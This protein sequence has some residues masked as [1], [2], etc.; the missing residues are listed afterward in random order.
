MRTAPE[1]NPSDTEFRLLDISYLTITLEE[2]PYSDRFTQIYFVFEVDSYTRQVTI[3]YHDNIH[4]NITDSY[5]SI[6][7][8][9]VAPLV[10]TIMINN[11]FT[12]WSSRDGII[13]IFSTHNVTMNG[14][15]FYNLY[16]LI[17]RISRVID[18]Q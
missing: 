11:T 10:N 9:F 6:I 12:N 3:N 18:F 15:Y 16:N 14:I 17:Q 8:F 5:Y 1:C 13:K 7:G 2:N 4:V